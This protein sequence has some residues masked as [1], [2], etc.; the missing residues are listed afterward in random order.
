VVEPDDVRL[1]HLGVA[2]QHALD[3]GR[4]LMPPRASASDSRDISANNGPIAEAPAGEARRSR[5]AARGP[6][7]AV[8]PTSSMD[9]MKS[10]RFRFDSFMCILW[11]AM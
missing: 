8:K 5:L 10:L 2:E 7:Q 3:L 1:G 4:P 6:A 11:T 9:S